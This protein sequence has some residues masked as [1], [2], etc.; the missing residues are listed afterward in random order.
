[1]NIY[2]VNFSGVKHYKSQ[3]TNPQKQIK[4][5]QPKYH[6]NIKPFIAGGAAALLL[7]GAVSTLPQRSK[8][9]TIPF[10]PE[11]MSITEM[12][13]T[14]NTN[15][16][17]IIDFNN[18]S[19]QNPPENLIELKMPEKF[20]YIQQEIEILQ[21]K[22]HTCVLSQKERSLTEKT[23]NALI[24]KQ[25]E[26]REVALTYSDG[27][28]LYININIDENAPDDIKKKYEFGANIE[29][30]KKL[31]DIKDGAIE[32]NNQIEAIWIDNDDTG[33]TGYFDY[34]RNWFHNGETIKV[35]VNSIKTD[36]INLSWYLK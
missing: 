26:Q 20:D 21:K 24:K 30:L 22:L 11:D 8:H 18:I 15:E 10:N 6:F 35:P 7:T 3:K 34:S 32:E 13:Q 9:I 19:E 2:P 14:Y 25:Q 16:K 36:N 12:A 31:F 4:Q 28:F 17:A 29:T 5:E 1:M 27:E 33:K 23:V